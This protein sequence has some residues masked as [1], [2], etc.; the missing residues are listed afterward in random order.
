MSTD[1]CGGQRPQI[2]YRTGVIG[3]SEPT[4]VGAKS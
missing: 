2:I 3:R 1:A 4:S